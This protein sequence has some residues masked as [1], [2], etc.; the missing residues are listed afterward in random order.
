MFRSIY[1]PNH[2]PILLPRHHL[3]WKRH[4]HDWALPSY[5]SHNDSQGLVKAPSHRIGSN[6]VKGFFM[7]HWIISSFQTRTFKATGPTNTFARAYKIL[8]RRVRYR[9]RGQIVT[10]YR[11]SS[12]SL[13]EFPWYFITPVKVRGWNSFGLSW[14]MNPDILLKL[15]SCNNYPLESTPKNRYSLLIKN[16]YHG[17]PRGHFSNR[18]DWRSLCY[19]LSY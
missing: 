17:I 6:L 13:I 8:Y 7:R 9:Y 12:M 14:Q 1:A 3:I 15:H 2:A 11:D 16:S 4:S 5:H 19:D 10:Q 18:K